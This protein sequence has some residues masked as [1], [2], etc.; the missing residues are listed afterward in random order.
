MPCQHDIIPCMNRLENL[1]TRAR[2]FASHQKL[3]I[4]SRD[5][6]SLTKI[7]ASPV[8]A[9]LF[10][11]DEAAGEEAARVLFAL[12]NCPLGGCGECELCQHALRGTHPD[13]FLVYAEGQNINLRQAHE[14][15]HF[16]QIAPVQS[17]L[18]F[19]VVVEAHLLN[20]EASNSLL[21]I[22]EEP[23]P[24]QLFIFITAKEGAV[25]DTL[26]SRLSAVRIHSQAE[27]MEDEFF[28]EV[29]RTMLEAIAD[30]RG[31]LGLD[32]RLGR[33]INEQ[34]ELVSQLANA[35]LL[36]ALEM[37]RE[38]GNEMDPKY[39]ADL[40]KRVKGRQDRLTKRFKNEIISALFER[41]LRTVNL[42]LERLLRVY[43]TSLEDADVIEEVRFVIDHLNQHQL[44]QIQQVLIEALEMLKADVLPENVFKGAILKFWKVVQF[45]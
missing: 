22:I 26:R 45:G 6:E 23:P 34:A 18:K 11:G 30:E 28:T 7:A 37:V 24:S 32:A 21:K 13:L 1:F 44:V 19:T 35:G 15:I 25:I 3:K 4:D 2:D 9:Y 17:R 16:A 42:S 31:L 43:D 39:V 20:I 33:R 12:L 5:L 27:I 36:E 14:I 10:A 38:M 40:K 29:Y 41:M 8:H